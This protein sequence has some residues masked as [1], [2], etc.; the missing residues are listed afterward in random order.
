M[1]VK[2]FK[3]F[4]KFGNL[5]A[6]IDEGLAAEFGATIP[7][8][9][10]TEVDEFIDAVGRD[11]TN[12]L[13]KGLATSRLRAHFKV[14]QTWMPVRTEIAKSFRRSPTWL[15]TLMAAAKDAAELGEWNLAALIEAG[16]DPTELK[17]APVVKTVKE[18][19][20][21]AGAKEARN[22]VAQAIESYRKAKDAERLERK[23]SNDAARAELG[24]RITKQYER[25]MKGVA[26]QS[27]I[28]QT[29]VI[30]QSMAAAAEKVCP[31]HRVTFTFSFI[32]D[33]TSG[34]KASP[35]RRSTKKSDSFTDSPQPTL[36]DVESPEPAVESKPATAP[37]TASPA[38]AATPGVEDI[39]PAT[40]VKVEFSSISGKSLAAPTVKPAEPLDY[41][42]TRSLD[43]SI[44]AYPGPSERG[45]ADD[46][47]ELEHRGLDE[48]Q[49]QRYLVTGLLDGSLHPETI[50]DHL[51]EF[52][53][54]QQH[55][56]L[57]TT[58]MVNPLGT[59]QS[60]L[61]TRGKRWPRNLVGGLIVT[62]TRDLRE[63]LRVFCTY[64]FDRKC[65]LFLPFESDSIDLTIADYVPDLMEIL[66][67]SGRPWLVV[68]GRINRGT[69]KNSL[70]AMDTGYLVNSA[71]D[72]GCKIF[73]TS[74]SELL[75]L[76]Q[77]GDRGQLLEAIRLDSTA[78]LSAG[79][80]FRRYREIPDFPKRPIKRDSIFARS[81]A[82]TGARLAELQ[83]GA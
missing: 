57:V 61:V 52:G 9:V 16:L 13:V 74:A 2:E 68:G 75:A 14:E 60:A 11:A 15:D 24:P 80:Y 47:S 45:N 28:E 51:D 70:S 63:K 81:A 48:A 37:L 53:A 12:N 4:L 54:A 55:T 83:P 17:Y 67:A 1:E 58:H 43:F 7:G 78:A 38:S 20:R 25:G 6:V 34:P 69:G 76:E 26:D 65:L 5:R 73:Y 10:V 35:R 22:I 72:A 64:R 82:T 18:S 23:R 33:N 42:V 79:S 62:S 39:G 30:L 46:H 41:F 66:E 40:T 44:R 8:G 31:G 3:G 59:I 36:F 77:G 29:K 27:R 19:A 21:P 50:V 49:P 56:F 32:G 71:R